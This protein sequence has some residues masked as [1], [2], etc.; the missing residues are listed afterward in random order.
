MWL[1]FR[2][3]DRRAFLPFFPQRK[4][5]VAVVHHEILRE[6]ERIEFSTVE[7]DRGGNGGNACSHE[8]ESRVLR[9]PAVDQGEQVCNLLLDE[10]C[11]GGRHRHS[12]CGGG[13]SSCWQ[14]SACMQWSRIVGSE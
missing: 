5:D 10:P 12:F 3:P 1:V 14:F 7:E 9:A 4:G 8:M 2:R 13:S 6:A 11:H